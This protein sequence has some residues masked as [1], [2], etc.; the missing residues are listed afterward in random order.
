MAVQGGE[1]DVHCLF[2]KIPGEAEVVDLYPTIRL[3]SQCSEWRTISVSKQ[4]ALLL[5]L[6]LR[7]SGVPALSKTHSRSSARYSKQICNVPFT[8]KSNVG[9]LLIAPWQESH[10]TRLFSHTPTLLFLRSGQLAEVQGNES[11]LISGA[12]VTV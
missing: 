11:A 10:I 7:V 9:R 8:K 5:L 1:E 2:S 3:D 4:S 12:A 6:L